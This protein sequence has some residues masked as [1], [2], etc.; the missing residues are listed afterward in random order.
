[1]K[2]KRGL[3]FPQEYT[4]WFVFGIIVLV[5]IVLISLVLQG[6]LTDGIGYV[7]SLMRFGQA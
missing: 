1:M 3:S 5:F 4:G 2:T 6:K 7:K